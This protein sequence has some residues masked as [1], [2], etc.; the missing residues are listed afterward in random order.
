MKGI[1]L[2]VVIVA[3][4]FLLQFLSSMEWDAEL[5]EDLPFFAAV[6]AF[7][8]FR[9]F[10]ERTEVK[11]RGPVPM[12]IPVPKPRAETEP[13]KEGQPEELGFEIPPLK[14]APKEAQEEIVVDTSADEGEE[15]RRQHSLQRHMAEKQAR[16]QKMEEERLARE[17][18]KRETRAATAGAWQ[19]SPD[20]LRNAVIWSEIIAPP[21]ALRK[22]R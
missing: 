8:L 3:V 18:Q 22:R 10:M 15:L 2:P 13:E 6:V 21:K 11:R 19:V 16:E 14:G 20:A 7:I 5:L 17:H 1:P 12:P 4:L 9:V